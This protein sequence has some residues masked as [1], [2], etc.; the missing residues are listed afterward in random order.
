VEP[1]A[2][3]DTSKGGNSDEV[4]KAWQRCSSAALGF[5][6]GQLY[7][8]MYIRKS[9]RFVTAPHLLS[10]DIWFENFPVTDDC[11]GQSCHH[12]HH[13]VCKSSSRVEQ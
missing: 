10:K 1:V 2:T 3:E 8:I 4:E 9:G 6:T 7:D 13:I 12:V 11:P 5:V